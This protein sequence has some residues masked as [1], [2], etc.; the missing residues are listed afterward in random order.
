MTLEIQVLAGN[1]QNDVVGLNRLMRSKLLLDWKTLT[2][3]CCTT[4]TEYPTYHIQGAGC[5]NEIGS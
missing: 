5:L 1:K 3:S 2:I 4:F